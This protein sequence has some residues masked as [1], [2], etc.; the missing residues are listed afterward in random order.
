V[1]PTASAICGVKPEDSREMSRLGW[2][3]GL[4]KL[5]TLAYSL[6]F[7]TEQC[8]YSMIFQD[9]DMVSTVVRPFCNVTPCSLVDRPINVSE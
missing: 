6:D 9:L 2:L 4:V 3:I 5:S 8:V 7:P 1:V